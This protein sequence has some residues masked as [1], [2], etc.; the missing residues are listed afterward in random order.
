MIKVA[1]RDEFHFGVSTRLFNYNLKRKRIEKGLTMQQ[2]A[3]AVGVS[4]Q[5]M[6]YYQSFRVYPPLDKAAKIAEVL[7]TDLNTL[8]P[9]EIASFRIKR[10]PEIKDQVRIPLSQALKLG[11]ITPRQLSTSDSAVDE[12]LE[13]AEMPAIVRSVLETLTPKEAKVVELRFG[14]A[15][16]RALTQGEVGAMFGV[17]R[18]RIGQIEA[19]AL[20]KLR[21]PSRSRKLRG[22][23]D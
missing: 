11:Y 8:F 23:L 16:G 19:K 12:E 3:D 17:T 5:T 7:E 4:L 20:R 14:F 6:F 18:T 10:Q 15:D 21:H 2:L 22:L 13:L 9:A 1:Q